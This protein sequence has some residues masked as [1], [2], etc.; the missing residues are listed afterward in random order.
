[1][2][3]LA[4]VDST[5][6]LTDP[7]APKNEHDKLLDRLDGTP[8]LM[9]REFVVVGDEKSSGKYVPISYNF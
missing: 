9:E 1:M 4:S 3:R 7:L 6:S 8:L 2:A 5:G